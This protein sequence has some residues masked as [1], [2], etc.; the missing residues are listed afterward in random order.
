MTEIYTIG[1]EGS[2]LADFLLTLKAADIQRVVDVRELPQ[3]RRPGFSKKA[4]SEALESR[5][6]SYEHRKKLGDPKAGRDA[7]R[8]GRHH[9]FRQ[10]FA[11]H[12]ETLAAKDEL[13]D[14]SVTLST[15]RCVLLCY[16]RDYR[17]CHSKL[18]CDDL[19]KLG[20][21]EIKHIGVRPLPLTGGKVVNGAEWHV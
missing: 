1:Y 8:A 12:M 5:N 15:E 7:A 17:L 9:E 20:A 2:S 14:L 16:E 18:L 3:S 21:F 11:A 10:I 4:L 6:I 13:M 19:Q